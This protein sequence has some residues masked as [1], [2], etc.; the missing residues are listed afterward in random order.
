MK[1]ALN[2]IM[3]RCSANRFFV[4][5]HICDEELGHLFLADPLSQKCALQ[6]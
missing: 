5:A 6:N 4:T 3:Y 1:Y 2:D